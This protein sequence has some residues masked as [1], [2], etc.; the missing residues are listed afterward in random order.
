MLDGSG[1]I[2]VLLDAEVPDLHLGLR[3]LTHKTQVGKG[4]PLR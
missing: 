4:V 1:K 3:G 2:D